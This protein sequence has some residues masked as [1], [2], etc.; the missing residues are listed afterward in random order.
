MSRVLRLLCVSVM[1]VALLGACSS[2]SSAK[3]SSTS[4]ATD[5]AAV[6]SDLVFTLPGDPIK[7]KVGD[8]FAIRLDAQPGTGYDWTLAKPLDTKVVQ[9]DGTA[10]RASKPG[11][12]GGSGTED[13]FFLAVGAGKQAIAL[14]YSRPWEKDTAPY[15]TA[16]FNVEVS[17]SG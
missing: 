17:P 7:V 2:D 5:V 11:V 12:I 8:R 3:S 6:P 10:Y 14:Q 16:T 15:D 13:L 9:A 4:A 1:A